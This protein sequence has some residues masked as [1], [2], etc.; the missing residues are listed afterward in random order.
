MKT[1][2]ISINNRILIKCIHSAMLESN[3]KLV[4]A[5]EGVFH[6]FFNF[7]H[8]KFQSQSSRGYRT[9]NEYCVSKVPKNVLGKCKFAD[10]TR[11]LIV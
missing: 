10:V 3:N 2:A 6:K 1:L 7:F 9:Q 11:D 8:L 5:K 4:V